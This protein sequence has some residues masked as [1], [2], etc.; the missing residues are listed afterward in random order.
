MQ[1]SRKFG[2]KILR[3]NLIISKIS[4]ASPANSAVIRTPQM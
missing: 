1:I 3:Q 4:E 2:E